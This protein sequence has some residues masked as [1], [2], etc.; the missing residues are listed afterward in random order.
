MWLPILK[1]IKTHLSAQPSLADVEIKIG[2]NEPVL[3]KR[4]LRIRR[5]GEPNAKNLSTSQP[6]TVPNV[7]MVWIDCWE[8]CQDKD[9]EKAYEL[10]YDLET[11]LEKALEVW[12]QIRPGLNGLHCTVSIEATASDGDEFRPSI[13]SRKIL[14]ISYRG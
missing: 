9:P 10:L 13:G 3:K 5:A 4:G 14:K 8:H 12:A 6:E 2:S 1:S 7:V 11:K